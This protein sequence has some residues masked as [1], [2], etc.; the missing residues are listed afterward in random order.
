MIIKKKLPKV[1]IKFLKISNV[2]LLFLV[3]LLFVAVINPY[4]VFKILNILYNIH[5]KIPTMKPF[6]IKVSG[7]YVRYVTTFII[8][9]NV[10]VQT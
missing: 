8:L 6:N 1:E 2:R 7:T 9:R 10:H 5:I 4:S 3:S